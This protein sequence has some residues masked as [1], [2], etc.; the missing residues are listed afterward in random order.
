MCGIF[1][2]YVDEKFTGSWKD[3]L[4][5]LAKLSHSRGKEASGIAIRHQ[6]KINVLRHKDSSIDLIKDDDFKSILKEIDITKGNLLVLGHAR[7]CTNGDRSNIF[8]N[9]PVLDKDIVTVH[10]GIIC[11]YEDIWKNYLNSSSKSDLDTAIIPPF[12]DESLKTL[13]IEE[14]LQKFYDVIEGDASLACLFARQ[15]VCTLTTNTGSLYYVEDSNGSIVFASQKTFINTISKKYFNNIT[16]HQLKP[17]DIKKIEL[18]SS[19]KTVFQDYNKVAKSSVELKRCTKCILPETFPGIA[20]D[21]KGV[22]NICNEYKSFKP[23]GRYALEE[24][25]DKNRKKDGSADCVLAFSGGRDS[26]YALHYLKCELGMNPITVTYDW[27]VV[28]DLA[29]RNIARMCGKLGVENILVSADIDKKRTN[30]RLNLNAW[31]KNP[32]LGM[33]GLLMAGDKQFFYYPQKVKKELDIGLLFLASHRM[34]Q[35]NFKSGFCGVHERNSWYFDVKITQ[36]LRMIWYFLSNFIKTP[37]YINRSLLDTAYSF[38]C[39]YMM[40]HDLTVFYDYIPWDED[41]INST[42]KEHYNWETAA[43]T[44][45]TWRIG[46]GTASF[47]N[48]IYSTI[49]GFTEHDTFRSTQIRENMITRDEALAMVK[50]D[51]VMRIEAMED[52]SKM[53]GFDLNKAINVINEAPKL[54][55]NKR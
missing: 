50:R 8:N 2:F 3:L 45:T 17:G 20:F 6:G 15:N 7:L 18:P 19:I 34:E 54:Y 43:S 31:F 28:T 51:N 13:S 30:V 9:Q 35:S 16:T 38:Y 11:N 46:D 41:V 1:G 5:D 12:L 32:D 40:K 49:A 24:L 42:L 29:R 33:V 37:S 44:T 4:N 14:S 27:G 21:E 47:Y 52:Y 26:S 39:S 10:N 22:C 36:K 23:Y 55:S 53:I 48:Y 25:C